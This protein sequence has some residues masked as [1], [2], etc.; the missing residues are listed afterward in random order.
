MES[1]TRVCCPSELSQEETQTC[2]SLIRGGAA[3]DPQSAAMELPLSLLVT[4]SHIG[5]HIAAVAV[6]KRSRPDYARAIINRSGFTFDKNMHELGYV[7]VQPSEQRRGLGHQIVR[8]LLS[9]FQGSLFA[10]T[11]HIGMKRIL[12]T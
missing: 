1:V 6:I 2:I 12:A 7:V 4:V 3:V 9:A 10:T 5:P 8:A 11:S